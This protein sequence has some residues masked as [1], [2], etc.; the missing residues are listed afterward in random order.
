MASNA[1]TSTCPA[2]AERAYL[3]AQFAKAFPV[4]AAIIDSARKAG[5]AS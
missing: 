1:T 5:L 3:Q 4:L 2:Q